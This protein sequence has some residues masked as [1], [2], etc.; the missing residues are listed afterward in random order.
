MM[1]A[2]LDHADVR[3]PPPLLYLGALLLGIGGDRLLRS[4]GLWRL[5]GLGLTRS[6]EVSAGLIVGAAGLAVMIAGAGLFVKLGTNV[7]PDRPS[8][9]L[10]TTGIYRVTRNPMYL[11]MS[12]LYA[13]LT[14]LFDSLVAWLFLPL[15]LIVI[16]TQ[17]IAREERYLEARFGDDYGAYKARVRRWV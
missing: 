2:Q 4:T 15:V 7:R 17:V 14:L 11:G 6:V 1:A 16:R 8:T 3:F 12:I 9:R 10:V 5:A 13:G